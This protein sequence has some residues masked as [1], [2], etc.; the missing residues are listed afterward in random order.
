MPI[1]VQEMDQQLAAKRPEEEVTPKPVSKEDMER[2]K[3]LVEA[4]YPLCW[5]LLTA[6]PNSS[7]RVAVIKAL[8]RMSYSTDSYRV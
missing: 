6:A 7:L 2:S 5:R 4:L 3:P 8:L 1:P